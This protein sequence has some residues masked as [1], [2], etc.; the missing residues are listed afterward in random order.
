MFRWGKRPFLRRWQRGRR[1]AAFG[2]GWIRMPAPPSR[3]SI[4]DPG[5]RGCLRPSRPAKSR[6]REGRPRFL[7]LSRCQLQSLLSCCRGNREEVFASPRWYWLS[8]AR[9]FSRGRGLA[10]AAALIIGAAPAIKWDAV[11]VRSI[12]T[13][14]RRRRI[15]TSNQTR[16]RTNPTG[17]DPL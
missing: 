15:L 16:E 8:I 13:T 9:Q 10:P 2:H 4:G 12:L 17:Y 11:G 1:E 7:Q 14:F 5:Q 3:C 6:A